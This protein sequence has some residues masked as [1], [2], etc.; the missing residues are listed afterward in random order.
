MKIRRLPVRAALTTALNLPHDAAQFVA[1]LEGELGEGLTRLSEGMA[2]NE[3][4]RILNKDGGWIS[5]SPLPVQPEPES[6][7]ALKTRMLERWPLTSL[8]DVF[9]E[10]D[11][12]TRFTDVF[13]SATAWRASRE[14]IQERLL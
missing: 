12:R 10:A 5:L 1:Q 13:R 14:I 2:S 6:L 8:L 7:A 9:K 3:Y 4:V 11:L